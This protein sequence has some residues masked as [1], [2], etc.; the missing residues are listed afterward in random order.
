MLFPYIII[1]LYHSFSFLEWWLSSIYSLYMNKWKYEWKKLP[2]INLKIIKLHISHP[3]KPRL[4]PCHRVVR[5]A[6]YHHNSRM[7][8]GSAA[9]KCH[10][11]FTNFN[12]YAKV[13]P[14]I[15]MWFI[16]GE[17]PSNRI[18]FNFLIKPFYFTKNSFIKIAFGCN[19][20]K[21]LKY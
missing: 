7:P 11:A 21:V 16:I 12:L 19:I 15:L 2:F 9:V 20:S 3:E 5:T 8:F 17:V 6:L 13:K 1:S 14:L 18:Y 10:V 4:M